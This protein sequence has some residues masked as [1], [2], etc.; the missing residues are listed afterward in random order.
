MCCTGVSITMAC[1]T[2]DERIGKDDFV[3]YCP[4]CSQD[5]KQACVV[6][7]LIFRMGTP[8][9]IF[10]P[11]LKL[12]VPIQSDGR[13]RWFRYDPPV[14]IVSITWHENREMLGE[15]A[16]KRL[17]LAYAGNPGSVCARLLDPFAQALRQ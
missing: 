4:Y 13:D 3:F 8:V 1:V 17:A 6:R 16:Y 9:F 7:L 10:T 5:A 15:L 2:W 11:Q 12:N 14:L